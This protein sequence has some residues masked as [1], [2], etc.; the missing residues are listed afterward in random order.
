MFTSE[1]F[2]IAGPRSSSPGGSPAAKQLS[3]AKKGTKAQFPIPRKEWGGKRNRQ[4]QRTRERPTPC[5][6]FPIKW[7]L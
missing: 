1:C 5:H 3:G 6:Q 2:F 7:A 4:L